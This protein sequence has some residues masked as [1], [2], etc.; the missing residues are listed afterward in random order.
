VSEKYQIEYKEHKLFVNGKPA[1]FK[2]HLDWL[3]FYEDIVNDMLVS[4]KDAE[5]IHNKGCRFCEEVL[6]FA[7]KHNLDTVILRKD[8]FDIL[9]VVV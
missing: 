1:E 7:K 2:S 4:I 6:K 3:R 9:G 8:S 5:E